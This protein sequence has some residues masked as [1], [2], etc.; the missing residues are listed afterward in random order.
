VDR[1]H[2]VLAQDRGLEEGVQ[3]NAAG[4]TDASKTYQ[5]LRG[6]T[7]AAG[8]LMMLCMMNSGIHQQQ[9]MLQQACEQSS[10]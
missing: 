6:S 10:M 5:E 3:R 8:I 9:N 7:N 4:Y 1:W 2:L